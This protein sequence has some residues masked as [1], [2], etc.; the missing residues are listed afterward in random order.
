MRKLFLA[1]TVLSASAV[2]GSDKPFA[3]DYSHLPYDDT[4]VELIKEHI[5]SAIEDKLVTEDRAP[6]VLHFQIAARYYE[7]SEA[8]SSR[9][10][11]VIYYSDG[12]RGRLIQLFRLERGQWRLVAANDLVSGESQLG[13]GFVDVNCDG[14]NEIILT[15]LAGAAGYQTLDLVRFTGDGLLVL[16]PTEPGTRLVGRR[17]DLTDNEVTCGKDI[18]VWLDG[19]VKYQP[20]RKRIYR[21]DSVTRTY[22]LAE[23][24]NLESE[25]R[26]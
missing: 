24:V 14:V 16:T 26:E 18:E 12:Y 1:L 9:S 15:S 2:G 25:G 17:W 6:S 13:I 7:F 21:L 22:K 3:L 10:A 5:P 4:L 23:E 8:D 20:D 11:A 19:P